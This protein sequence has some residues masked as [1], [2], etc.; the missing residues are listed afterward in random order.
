MTFQ[1][2]REESKRQ[3]EKVHAKFIKDNVACPTELARANYV[4]GT[5][6]KIHG[7]FIHQSHCLTTSVFSTVDL[8]VFS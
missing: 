7:E 2:E 5:W 3:A 6:A 1:I 4:V 8:K